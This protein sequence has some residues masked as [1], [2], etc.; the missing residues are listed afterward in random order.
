MT[1]NISEL[2]AGLETV[3]S[4]MSTTVAVR[5][6]ADMLTELDTLCGEHN[7]TRSKIMKAAFTYYLTALKNNQTGTDVI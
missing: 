7:T 2:L 4:P 3:Y 5:M 1:I 6:K